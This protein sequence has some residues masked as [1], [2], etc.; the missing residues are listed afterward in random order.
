MDRSQGTTAVP[1]V[2]LEASS[3][4]VVPGLR[5]LGTPAGGPR[6]VVVEVVSSPRHFCAAADCRTHG[7][8]ALGA[9]GHSHRASAVGHFARVDGARYAAALRSLLCDPAHGGGTPQQA[10]RK[11]QALQR[12]QAGHL[13]SRFAQ[14]PQN[15]GGGRQRAIEMARLCRDR[16]AP[17]DSGLDVPIWISPQLRFYAYP[18][19]VEPEQMNQQLR[20]GERPAG[21]LCID[22]TRPKQPGVDAVHHQAFASSELEAAAQQ[23]SLLGGHTRRVQTLDDGQDDDWVIP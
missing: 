7:V 17:S 4:S 2:T 19:G 1:N 11:N 8:L 15:L 16:Y 5:R 18:T 10:M 9:G 13:Q 3:D 20:R 23:V 6:I 21:C 14:E 12:A 22:I